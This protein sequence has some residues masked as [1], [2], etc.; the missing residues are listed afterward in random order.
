MRILELFS[1]TGSL[2]KAARA[3]GHEVVTLD[4]SPR[5][6]PTIRTNLLEWDP[7]HEFPQDY[8][9]ASC[10][11]EAYSRARTTGGPRPL[12]LADAVVA[13][14]LAVFHYFSAAHWTLENPA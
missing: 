2:A 3:R 10:P 4:I 1:G 14:T 5:H 7:S 12:E 9:H 11:C 13:K 6:N 8:I